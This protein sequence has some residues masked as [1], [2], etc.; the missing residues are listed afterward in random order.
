MTAEVKQT[1]TRYRLKVG[2]GTHRRPPVGPGDLGRVVKPGE[3]FQPTELEL[4]DFG[5][6]FK[7]I[8]ELPDGRII[9]PQPDR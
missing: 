7:E 5:D 8:I 1:K 6:K 3:L 2:V 9:T 4:R